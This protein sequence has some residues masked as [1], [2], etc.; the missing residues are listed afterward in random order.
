VQDQQIQT[1]ITSVFIEIFGAILAQHAYGQWL[2][3]Q[4]V[5]TPWGQGLGEKWGSEKKKNNFFLATFPSSFLTPFYRHLGSKMTAQTR[6]SYLISFPSYRGPKIF[7][8]KILTP[9]SENFVDEFGRICFLG[10]AFT[11]AYLEQW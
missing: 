7:A 9:V 6:R 2:T 11:L 1:S 3:S 5:T 10:I 8:K 4:K